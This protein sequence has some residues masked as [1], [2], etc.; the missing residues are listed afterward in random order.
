MYYSH[1]YFHKSGLR[2]NELISQHFSTLIPLVDLLSHI[3][4]L[5]STEAFDSSVEFDISTFFFF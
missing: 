1:I 5:E 3:K 2:T 4:I